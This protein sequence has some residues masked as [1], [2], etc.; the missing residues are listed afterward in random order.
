MVLPRK[1]REIALCVLLLGLPLVFLQANL[2][3]PG[4]LNFIDR[5]VLAVSAPMQSAIAWLIGGIGSVWQR[6]VYLVGVQRENQQLKGENWRLK[7]TL[8][9]DQRVLSRVKHYERLLAFRADRGVETIGARV[10]ASHASPFIRVLKLKLDR[11][12]ASVTRGL[13]VVTADGVVGRV[14][15]VHGDYSDIMLAVDRESAIDVM[16]QR[17]GSRGMLR[18][19]EGKDR[20]RCKLDYL[21][22]KHDVAVGDLIVT[23]GVAGVFPRGLPVGRVLHVDDKPIGLYRRVEVT[24]VVDFGAIR[25]VLII[26]APPPPSV[27]GEP[28][29]RSLASG[30]MP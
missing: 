9:R 15:R 5:G 29:R 13:A 18:G 16:V 12:R 23:S 7:N 4:A 30:F 11:G 14:G 26:L 22:K 20:Y 2:K 25:D 27:E 3:D 21:L 17:T 8:Q 1:A 10:I 28:P 24:P 6:Y 19:I